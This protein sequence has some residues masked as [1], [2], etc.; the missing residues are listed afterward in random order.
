M[1]NRQFYTIGQAAEATGKAKSTIKKA[2][3]D[4]TLSVYEKTS[5]GFKIEAS[6]LD[7]VF[8]FLNGE[9][10]ENRSKKQNETVE[11]TPLNSALEIELKAKAEALAKEQEERTRERDRMQAEIDRLEGQMDAA[12]KR[13]DN[14][15]AIIEDMR[16]K[17]PKAAPEPE[18]GSAQVKLE[19]ELEKL[20]G[21]MAE[22]KR[23]WWKRRKAG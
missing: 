19:E 10:S 12:G 15:L 18:K 11:K 21:E 2:I 4:S 8:P 5:R 9:R 13:Y 17:E 16:P 22:M 14:A 7:R 1:E 20:R 6:E 23:P 3:D